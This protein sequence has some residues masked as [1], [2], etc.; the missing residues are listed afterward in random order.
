MHNITAVEGDEPQEGPV[1]DLRAEEV[2]ALLPAPQP[3]ACAAEQ[4]RST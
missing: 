1:V 2:T 4:T 3:G